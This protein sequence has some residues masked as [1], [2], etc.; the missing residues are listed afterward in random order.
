[1]THPA[2]YRELGDAN[3]ALSRSA[4]NRSPLRTGTSP[5]RTL[6]RKGQGISPVE[7]PSSVFEAGG[8]RLTPGEIE[9]HGGRHNGHRSGRRGVA[10]ADGLQTRHDTLGGP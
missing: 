7:R 5:N 10:P 4:G 3:S 2:R 8:Y 1:V 6:H 9:D